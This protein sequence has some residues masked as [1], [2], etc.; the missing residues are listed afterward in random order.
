MSSKIGIVIR[1]EFFERVSKKSFI[2]STLLMPILMLGLMVAPALIAAFSQPEKR[3]IAVVDDSGIIA[4]SLNNDDNVEYVIM[5]QPIDSVLKKT[6]ID[7]VLHINKDIM[8]S[9]SGSIAFYSNEASSMQIETG[10]TSQI[11]Q[12]IENERLKNYNIENLDEILN[13][14][15]ADISMQTFRLDEENNSSASSSFLSYIIGVIMTLILYLFLLLYGQMVMTSIIEEKNNRVLEI[16]V[17]SIKPAQ[18]MMGKIL[19]IGSVAV[20]Q[21][22]IWAIM[23]VI[24]S[25]ALLPML[26]PTE[27]MGDIAASNAGT[28]NAENA[29]TDIEMIHALATLSNVGYILKIFSFLLVFLIGGF[30]F[31]S[32]LY[33]AIG[34]SVDNIQDAGQFQSIVVFPI[35]IGFVL[36]MSIAN[37][38]NSTMATV[39]SLI[40]FTSPMVM[41]ARI[42]FGIATWE[43]V[44]SLVILYISFILLV[45]LA[46]KIYRVGIFMYGKKPSIKEIIK[47]INY[48]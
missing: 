24:I 7:G 30:L 11:E 17:S 40:P 2:I 41:I 39:M 19:G 12:T 20:V 1:R 5:E 21:V 29:V 9:K 38:P 42:P 18:L 23:L 32:S 33:V 46:A 44:T 45:Q 25:G 47:W 16:V 8:N 14:I 28:L 15:K 43:I 26:I 10:I 35:L 34:S 22:L 37:D 6:D 31:Y 27:I 3:I 13:S 36:A 4:S 48:K